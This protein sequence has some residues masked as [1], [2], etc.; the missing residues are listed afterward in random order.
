MQ[1]QQPNQPPVQYP[2]Q[3]APGSNGHGGQNN[4]DFILNPA[5]PPKKSPFNFGGGSLPGKVI[6]ILGGVFLLVIILAVVVNMSGGGTNKAGLLAIAQDQ[7]ELLRL[8]EVGDTDVK[9]QALQNFNATAAPSITSDQSAFLTYMGNNDLKVNSKDLALGYD[10][11]V[12]TQLNN[13]LSAGTFETA[14]KD[15]M[16]KKLA[17]Y[18]AALTA[19]YKTAGPKGKAVLEAQFNNA[20][21]LR[22]QLNS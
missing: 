9:S 21:L 11:A 15:V 19:A 22:T 2:P 20:K 7:T 5:A 4:F 16:D 6:A 8:I 18:Q 14:Y 10:S 12:D 17:E 3:P 1:P 13:A